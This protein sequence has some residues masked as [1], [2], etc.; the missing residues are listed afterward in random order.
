MIGT[1]NVMNWVISTVKQTGVV[2]QVLETESVGA[3]AP[4]TFA[5]IVHPQAFGPSPKT[6]GQASTSML[7]TVI[8]QLTIQ[9]PVTPLSPIDRRLTRGVDKLLEL[10]NANIDGSDDPLGFTDL[11][12]MEGAALAAQFGWIP[13]PDGVMFRS[14]EI[15]VPVIVVDAYAQAH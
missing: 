4:G 11:Y 1:D 9:T 5:A 10:L 2:D 12:G 8:I 15:T 14:A 13:G 6:S 7:I 3:G